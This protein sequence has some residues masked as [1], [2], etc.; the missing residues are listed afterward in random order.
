MMEE[1]PVEE[2]GGFLSGLGDSISSWFSG[3]GQ[4]VQ[5]PALAGKGPVA[6]YIPSVTED[7]NPQDRNDFGYTPVPTAI[8]S[9]YNMG[10][11]VKQFAHYANGGPVQYLRG[12][13]KVGKIQAFNPETMKSE[14]VDIDSAL[15]IK[16]SMEKK[17]AINRLE[18]KQKPMQLGAAPQTAT[19]I[20]S[21]MIPAAGGGGAQGMPVPAMEPEIPRFEQQGG[22][23]AGNIGLMQAAQQQDDNKP[24]VPHIDSAPPVPGS[25]EA[26]L[27]NSSEAVEAA[28]DEGAAAE[29]QN[30]IAMR[31]LFDQK[32]GEGTFDAIE[33]GEME[34]TEEQLNFEDKNFQLLQELNRTRASGSML[35]PDAVDAQNF[36]AQKEQSIIAALQETPVAPGYEGGAVPSTCRT[37]RTR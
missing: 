10:G 33:S 13:G 6:E 21:A 4:D 29:Q 16:A 27:Q 24:E 25:D 7:S 9:S 22:A 20:T 31:K 2:E 19:D 23:L 14:L 26:I 28:E 15:G 30:D 35:A 17:A 36:N 37:R 1:P 32:Y 5:A 11:G 8:G 34:P 12:G 18:A 3:G